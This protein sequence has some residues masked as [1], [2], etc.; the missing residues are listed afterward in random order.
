MTPEP[1][2]STAAIFNRSTPDLTP[3]NSVISLNNSKMEFIEGQHSFSYNNG[4]LKKKT[5][6]TTTTTTITTFVQV[7]ASEHTER[8]SPRTIV[9]LKLV[10]C[11]YL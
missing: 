9:S 5:T 11:S 7:D 3:T 6:T 8:P 10:K 2:K 1:G 4:H